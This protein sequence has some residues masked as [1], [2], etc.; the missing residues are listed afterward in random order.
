[1]TKSQ[2]A[3]EDFLEIKA[4]R[5]KWRS[6]FN[7]EEVDLALSAWQ[8]SR[9]AALEEAIN[10]LSCVSGSSDYRRFSGKLKELL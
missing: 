7:S 5:F 3:F 8:A 10:V 9:K 2:L 4:G 6:Y 1:M